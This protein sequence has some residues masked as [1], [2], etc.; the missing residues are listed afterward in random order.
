MRICKVQWQ[1][2]QYLLGT[3][4]AIIA[5][6]KSMYGVQMH[7]YLFIYVRGHFILQDISVYIVS[8][9]FHN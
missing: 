6:H 9:D 5:T 2:V 3:I 7:T 8:L 1:L 4:I